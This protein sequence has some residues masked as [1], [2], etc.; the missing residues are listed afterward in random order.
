MTLD[1]AMFAHQNQ[2]VDAH[3]WIVE[4]RPIQTKSV[5]VELTAYNTL[6]EDVADARVVAIQK[7]FPKALLVCAASHGL[8]GLDERGAQR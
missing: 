8:I 3:V 6:A 2:L 4:Q 7:G 5:H 1:V